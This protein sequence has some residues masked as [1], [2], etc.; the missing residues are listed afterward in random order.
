MMR[1]I[2][3]FICV[4]IILLA[5][6]FFIGGNFNNFQMI[7]RPQPKFQGDILTE[8]IR[9][10]PP[11]KQASSGGIMP[12]PPRE[13]LKKAEEFARSM[14]TNEVKIEYSFDE[15]FEKG[16]GDKY[17]YRLNIS[18]A[19]NPFRWRIDFSGP[20][21]NFTENFINDGEKY[22]VCDSEQKFCNEFS[23]L[24][25]PGFSTPLPVTEFLNN[26]LDP[27]QLKKLLPGVK[28]AQIKEDDRVIA[29]LS[30]RCQKATDEIGTVEICLGKE[31][32]IPLSIY[33]DRGTNLG[34]HTIEAQKVSLSPLAPDT[35]TPP[36]PT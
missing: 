34:Q 6:L 28:Q 27:L 4:A 35:F 16:G 19:A 2:L 29:G 18:V 9:T 5:G 3:A 1:T 15:S 20:P 13:A 21:N 11:Q 12:E 23:S 17:S 8:F 32:G 25:D 10:V 31:S 22:Y 24:T 36:Y 14:V 26:F 33:V 30:S 7:K